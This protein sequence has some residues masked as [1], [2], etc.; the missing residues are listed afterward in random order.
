[1]SYTY[2]LVWNSKFILDDNDDVVQYS[3][4]SIANALDTGV[5]AVSR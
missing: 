4:Y 2:I 3:S 5:T 1:M